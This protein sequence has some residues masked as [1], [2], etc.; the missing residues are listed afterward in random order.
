[1]YNFFSFTFTILIGKDTHLLSDY[2]G[3][4]PV[5]GG[6]LDVLELLAFFDVPHSKFSVELS[7]PTLSTFSLLK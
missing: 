3:D 2:L 5:A 4:P 1:V 6:S 7:L